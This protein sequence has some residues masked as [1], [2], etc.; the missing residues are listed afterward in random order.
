[1][2]TFFQQLVNGLVLGA[3]Y[4]LIALGY[5]MVYGIVQLINFAHGEI[6]ML[7]GFGALTMYVY[8]L[9]DGTPAAV[10]LPLMLVFA[11]VVSVSAAVG[12]ERFAYRPLRSAP[13]LAPLIT[14]LGVSISL[15]ELIRNFYPDATSA[16]PFPQLLDPTNRVSLGGGVSI[17]EPDLATVLVAVAGM[18]ALT[19]F[20]R[21]SRTGRAMQ[22][23]AQ[24]PDTARLMGIDTDRIIVTAFALGASLAALAGLMHGLRF[25]QVDFKMGFLTGVKAFTAA[26]LGGIGNISGAV[27]GGFTLGLVEVMAT[28]YAPDPFSGGAWKDAWAFVVLIVVLVFRPTGLLG[29]RVAARA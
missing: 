6:F 23:T 3:N 10:A 19:V 27:L 1:M 24:D 25:G 9:P 7:G 11:V 2:S 18:V 17:G 21:R 20:V 4:G 29:E 22:A 15:Q 26:V 16:R 5:T 12:M 14:A 28:A 13:R 8:I